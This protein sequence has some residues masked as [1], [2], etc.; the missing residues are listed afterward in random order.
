[1]AIPVPEPGLVISYASL[2]VIAAFDRLRGSGEAGLSLR[3]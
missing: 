2:P 3:V 1:M